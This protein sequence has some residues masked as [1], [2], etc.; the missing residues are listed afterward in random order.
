AAPAGAAGP[1]PSRPPGP[2]RRVRAPT[3]RPTTG[4][5]TPRAPGPPAPRPRAATAAMLAR[6]AGPVEAP[7]SPTA[8][9]PDLEPGHRAHSSLIPP[10]SPGVVIDAERGARGEA[11]EAR[12]LRRR[13]TPRA[14]ALVVGPVPRVPGSRGTRRAERAH[15]LL[16]DAAEQDG[17]APVRPVGILEAD[18]ARR[19][20]RRVDVRR[21]VHALEEQIAGA[22]HQRVGRRQVGGAQPG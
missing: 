1:G 9:P 11:G 2:G 13:Q 15:R 14:E 21:H 7:P 10:Q 6:P 16:D 5:S 18:L 4:S 3:A 12:E 8:V 17:L 22:G 20:R 19:R